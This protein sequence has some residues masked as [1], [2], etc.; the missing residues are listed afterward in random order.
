M[1][2]NHTIAVAPKE[3]REHYVDLAGIKHR[4]DWCTRSAEAADRALLTTTAASSAIPIFHQ[5]TGRHLH[6]RSIRSSDPVRR[7]DANKYVR[8]RYPAVFEAVTKKPEERAPASRKPAA[9]YRPSAAWNEWFS[10]FQGIAP[11][12]DNFHA[13]NPWPMLDYRDMTHAMIGQLG[14]EEAE[15]RAALAVLVE[16]LDPA[17][18]STGSLVHQFYGDLQY[19]LRM[20]PEN[21]S[22]KINYKMLKRD[23]P[24]VYAELYTGKT[25]TVESVLVSVVYDPEEEITE[26]WGIW[27]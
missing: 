19:L 14:T 7:S 3:F 24:E 20:P 6:V 23:Y 5:Q 27:K 26:A 1:A 18:F 9:V 4:R 21:P 15:V 11:F 2:I 10:E 22:P 25:K 16:G 13:R 8:S 17:L 12:P